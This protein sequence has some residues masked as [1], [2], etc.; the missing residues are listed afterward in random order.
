MLA[1]RDEVRWRVEPASNDDHVT[2]DGGP[3]L[4]GD[5]SADHDQR[6]I[7]DSG[8]PDLHAAKDDGH[9]AAHVT[10]DRRRTEDDD[11]V[12]DGLALLEDEVLTDAKHVSAPDVV[13]LFRLFN[14]EGR[15]LGGS[16]DV[17]QGDVGTESGLRRALRARGFGA[18][19]EHDRGARKNGERKP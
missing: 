9:V 15:A 8:A 14:R 18:R 12:T 5:V 4:N 17:G 19:R 3:G 2:V 7:D 16:H 10:L 6:S 11:D 13:D 1:A